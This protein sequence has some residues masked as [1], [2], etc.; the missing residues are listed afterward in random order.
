MSRPRT[1][2]GTTLPGKLAATMLK[3]LAAELSDGGRLSR[4][5]ALRADGAVLDLD[6]SA[7]L[8]TAQVQGTRPRPYVVTLRTRA[9]AQVPSRSEVRIRCTCSDDDGSGS[10]ACKHAVATLFALADEVAIDPTVLERWRAADPETPVATLASVAT[11]PE[12]SD[13]SGRDEQDDR[14]RNGARSE[15]A[16]DR[17]AADRIDAAF[18]VP[19]GAA[20]PT[21][22]LVAPFEHPHLT[23]PLV[24][25]VLRE[26]IR[27]LSERTR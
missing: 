15:S 21:V 8:V 27:E 23:D 19:A 16:E 4:G 26:A 2:F 10:A 17:A 6:V 18:S 5:K 22:P 12:A 1:P 20:L 9:G 14:E 13:P 7:G 3:V 25:E 11:G 24:D